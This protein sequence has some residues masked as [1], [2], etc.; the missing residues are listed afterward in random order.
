M[1]GRF[2][3]DLTGLEKLGRAR[4]VLN[5]RR[6]AGRVPDTRHSLILATPAP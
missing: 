1:A 5:D 2:F 3:R 4:A 6:S